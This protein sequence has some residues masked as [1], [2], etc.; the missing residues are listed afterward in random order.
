MINT[1]SDYLQKLQ[2]KYMNNTSSNYLF[3]GLP[4]SGKTTYFALMAQHLQNV[5]NRTRNRKFRYLPTQVVNQE[6]GE[7]TLDEDY[8]EDFIE[9]CVARIK[10]QKWP[11]K[12]QG[13]ETGYSFEF[14]K[15]F[16]LFG[17]LILQRFLYRKALVE[18]HDYPGEAFET[19]F[20]VAA[21]PTDEMFKIGEDLKAR[22]EKAR[23]LFL[24]LD[25]DA[26]FNSQERQK[27]GKTITRLF[28]C[29]R[30]F[31]ER[32][33]IAII[34]NKLELFAGNVPDLKYKLRKEYSNA[35]AYLPQNHKFFEVY[36]L[37]TVVTNDDG[38][39]IP[40]K[41]LHPR[42]IL[43]PIKWMLKI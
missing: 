37:G 39:V 29:I 7:T 21:D 15:E 42:N 4:K 28:R 27:L 13:Y 30:K 2:E 40:P 41:P 12:T 32:V 9:D 18:Y 23:G 36:T 35:Y 5:A 16:S 26:I 38:S 34:F 11:M 31:N 14:I 19:A 6:T 1:A 8:T 3:L 10:E 43:D 20:G 24:I 22:I 17:K 33:K 25:A